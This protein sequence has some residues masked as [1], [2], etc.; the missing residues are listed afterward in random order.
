MGSMR[1]GVPREIKDGERRVG[2]LPDGARALADE[3]HD[4]L[5]ERSAGL[6]VGF[7]DAQYAGAGAM[8]VDHAPDIWRCELIVKVKELQPPEYALLTPGTT[9]FGYAQLAR[10]PEL[11]DVVLRAGVRIIAYELVRDASGALPLLA[12]M[13]R[14]AGR[15][16]PFVGAQSLYTDRGGSGV[17][18]TGIDRVAGANVLVIGA[19]TAGA[20]A[21]RIASRL[22][23]RV[24]VLSRGGNRLNA[25]A[26]EL[27]Q[28][29]TPIAASTIE[30]MGPDGFA[31]AI[32]GADLVIG[33]VLDPG[34]LSPRLITRVHLRSMRAGSALVDIGI[35]Q[36]GI[37]ETSRMTTLSNPTYVDERIV[38]YAVPNMPSLVARTATE[39]L[40]AATLPYVHRLA[41]VGV[42]RAL[43]DDPGLAQGMLVAGGA[44][45]HSDLAM[46]LR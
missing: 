41:R 30:K 34:K 11:V 7:D 37:A 35:D 15:L 21:A 6:A 12:P 4:V 17:L 24:T 31:E 9:I 22:G 2:L 32:A 16:A 27:A 14:I 25:L 13:S 1:I 42:S 26:I 39:A 5:V 3:G 28:L 29:G 36:G 38:H 44:I 8:L 43:A 33:A 40:T 19:G 18:L 10:D 23:C 46:A 45:V 20:E